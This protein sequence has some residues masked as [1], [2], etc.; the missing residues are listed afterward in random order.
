M[1][2]VCS[3]KECIPHLLKSD[4][5][6]ILNLS[7]PLSLNPKWFGKHVAYTMAKYGMSMCV[8]GM[9]HEFKGSIGVNAL[10]PKTNI[11]TAAIEM[12]LGENSSEYSRKP[13]IVADAA[14]HI[15]CSNP[16]ELTGNFFIDE[17]VLRKANINDFKQYACNPKN[18]DHLRPDIFLDFPNDPVSEKSMKLTG[19]FGNG[20]KIDS[21]FKNIETQ[22][23]EDLVQKIN[24]VYHFKISG[25]EA[26]TW[27]MNLKDGKGS[28]GRGESGV[29]AKATF[30]MN[31]DD[32]LNMFSGNLKA[33]SAFMLDKLNIEGKETLQKAM[34]LEQIMKSLKSKL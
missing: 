24:A 33:T 26:G 4:H 8:L 21:I 30:K 22:L 25:N 9:A 31:S 19:P 16:K 11:Q 27:Y 15:L 1:N 6:H 2:L 32:L 3:S 14:Y 23:S 18:A 13:E 12:L 10:W 34:K 28:C 20:G 7:P 5:A 29:T 17:D